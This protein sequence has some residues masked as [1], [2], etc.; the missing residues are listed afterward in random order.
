MLYNIQYT[1]FSRECRL[2]IGEWFFLQLL[3]NMPGFCLLEK[4]ERGLK[5]KKNM[6]FIIWS[7]FTLYD[8]PINEDVLG[9]LVPGCDEYSNIFRCEYSF[10]SYS[11]NFFDTNIF[12]Y[13]F[14]SFFLYEYIRIFVRIVFF[15]RIYSDIRLYR[16]I[17][18]CHTLVREVSD[19]NPISSQFSLSFENWHFFNLPLSAYP[20]HGY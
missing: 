5:E 13:W 19:A 20:R 11:Y 12:G 15:I 2:N 1:S 9:T 7:E 16:K 10:V 8:C 17:Y 6:V 14:V 4:V 18:I 3:A